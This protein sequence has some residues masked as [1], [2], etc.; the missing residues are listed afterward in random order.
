MLVG[1]RHA[2]HHFDT[3][4]ELNQ[5]GSGVTPAGIQLNPDMM[6]NLPTLGADSSDTSETEAT[7]LGRFWGGVLPFRQASFPGHTSFS[8]FR[9][10]P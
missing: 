9:P 5:F 8:R 4:L 10:I 3:Q 1:W 6:W 2:E 7:Q